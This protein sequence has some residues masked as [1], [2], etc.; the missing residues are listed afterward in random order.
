GAGG[1]HALLVKPDSSL[2]AW[3]LG[4]S[5]QLGFTPADPY[6]QYPPEQVSGMSVC[7]PQSTT[8]ALP[9]VSAG[10]MSSL[11]LRC[12]GTVW[13]WGWTWGGGSVLAP[14]QVPGLA[15]VSAVSS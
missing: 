3:G 8:P 2:W 13:T 7:I 6:Y 15:G 12:D 11:A 1:F 4:R 14:V 9:Q 5:G 10:Y